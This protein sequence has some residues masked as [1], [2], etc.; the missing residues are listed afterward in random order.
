MDSSP[1]PPRQSMVQALREPRTE[2]VID[3]LEVQRLEVER[4]MRLPMAERFKQ[5]HLPDSPISPDPI[6]CR[7][8]VRVSG[9]LNRTLKMY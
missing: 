6:L 1:E 4:C 3:L 9:T 2:P 5:H 8:A 7:I